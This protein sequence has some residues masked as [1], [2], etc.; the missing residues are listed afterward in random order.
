MDA[1]SVFVEKELICKVVEG[2]FHALSRL[3]HIFL[4]SDLV[5]VSLFVLFRSYPF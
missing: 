5:A 2:L 1:S 4:C 3:N